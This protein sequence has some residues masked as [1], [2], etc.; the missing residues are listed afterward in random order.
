MITPSMKS[1]RER[2]NHR[3]DGDNT[4][5]LW[6]ASYWA[7][8]ASSI[9]G[10]QGGGTRLFRFFMKFSG[11]GGNP[12]CP[13]SGQTEHGAISHTPA[14]SS[15]TARGRTRGRLR[16]PQSIRREGISRRFTAAKIHAIQRS[17]TSF[18]LQRSFVEPLKRSSRLSF[19]PMSGSRWPRAL[20]G[21][22]F[23]SPGPNDVRPPRCHGSSLQ[24]FTR[25]ASNCSR[26]PGNTISAS[27]MPLNCAVLRVVGHDQILQCNLTLQ[28]D[29]VPGSLER[30]CSLGLRNSR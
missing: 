17:T 6:S 29:S 26:A 4:G 3:P 1:S 24:L 8:K 10:P 5:C 20:T 23:S 27:A 25:A 18:V 14:K 16:S 22:Q 12:H 9:S 13:P 28:N 7:F 15:R 21:I 2:G 11:T 30:I 19:S